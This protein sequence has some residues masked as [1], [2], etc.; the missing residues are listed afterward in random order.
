[1]N[2]V[3]GIVNVHGRPQDV[4]GGCCSVPLQRDP[5]GM[6]LITFKA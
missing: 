6:I 4:V 3:V 1:M 2:L 5:S